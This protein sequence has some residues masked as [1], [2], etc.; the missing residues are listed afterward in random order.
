[1]HVTFSLERSYPGAGT[2]EQ[3]DALGAELEQDG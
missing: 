3:L 1:M 2:A